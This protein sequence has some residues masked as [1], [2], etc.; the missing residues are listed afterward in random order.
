[1]CSFIGRLFGRPLT[2]RGRYNFRKKVDN[3]GGF[4]L[5]EKGKKGGLNRHKRIVL[6]ILDPEDWP[7]GVQERARKEKEDYEKGELPANA[8][9]GKGPVVGPGIP[10]NG[11]FF[12]IIDGEHRFAEFPDQ[13]VAPSFF[14]L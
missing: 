13:Y 7:E 14:G 5:S 1:M 2:K 11:D 10:N 6:R 9:K 8:N 4:L 3:D 12:A